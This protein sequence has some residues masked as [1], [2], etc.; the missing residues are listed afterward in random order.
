MTAS[1]GIGMFLYSMLCLF[2]GAGI[3]YYFIKDL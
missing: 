3:V 2:I 1:F